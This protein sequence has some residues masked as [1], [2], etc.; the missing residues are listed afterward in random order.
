VSSFEYNTSGDITRIILPDNGIV[1]YEWYLDHS[2]KTVRYPDSGV[3]EAGY[4]LFGDVRWI[5]DAMGNRSG[6]RYDMLRQVSR[7]VKNLNGV[8]KS[9]EF[10]YNENGQVT[11]VTDARGNSTRFD[12]DKAG[13]VWKIH[14][15]P[16]PDFP[17]GTMEQYDYDPAGNL[18]THTDSKGKTTSFLYDPNG[19]VREVIR[20][21]GSSVTY[22]YD[23]NGNALKRSDHFPTGAGTGDQWNPVQPDT[24][25]DYQYDS[26]DRLRFV[27]CKDATGKI[28][29]R[30]KTEYDF[31][32]AVTD[33]SDIFGYQ[34][35]TGVKYGQGTVIGQT[36]GV[37]YDHVYTYGTDAGTPSNPHTKYGGGNIGS[38]YG[39]PGYGAAIKYGQGTKSS[40]LH[41]DNLSRITEYTD[42]FGNQ[43]HYGYDEL[44]RPAVVQYPN[45]IITQYGYDAAGRLHNITHKRETG[46]TLRSFTYQYDLNRN[47][48]KIT[49]EDGS[50]TDYVYDDWNR[51]TRET[52]KNALGMTTL[53]IAYSF[54]TAGSDQYGDTGNI[55]SKIV[56]RNGGTPE[57]TTFTYDEYNKLT[58]INHPGNVAE[59]LTYNAN[60][61]L[62]QSTKTG[63]GGGSETT[64]YYWNDQGFLTKVLLP[65][66]EPVEY[67]YDGV[68]RLV[69]RKDADGEQIFV[70][71]GWSIMTEQD[72]EGRR[73]YYTGSSSQSNNST[74]GA[75]FF[76]FNHRGDTVLIT[77]QTGEVSNELYYE[78]YG[79]VTDN[80]GTPIPANSI[81]TSTPLPPLFVG[82]Y[83]IRYD[84]K[85]ELSYMRFRWYDV[86]NMRS[87]SSDLLLDI[88]RYSYGKQNPINWFDPFGL[89]DIIFEGYYPRQEESWVF[90][91]MA[92]TMANDRI[93]AG[94]NVVVNRYDPTMVFITTETDSMAPWRDYTFTPDQAVPWANDR[95]EKDAAQFPDEELQN[96]I[97]LSH[98]SEHGIKLGINANMANLNIRDLKLPKHSS[99]LKVWV[100][101]CN[102]SRFASTFYEYFNISAMG[103]NGPTYYISPVSPMWNFQVPNKLFSEKAWPF[104]EI[105]PGK[106]EDVQ[107]IHYP[108]AMQ[109][110]RE[111]IL[112]LFWNITG[113]FRRDK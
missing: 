16:T 60:G 25:T 37:K 50:L 10:E 42:F 34:Y 58:T 109:S 90:D 99:N 102:G 91:R 100:F 105:Y 43:Y 85:T 94:I 95:F 112:S 3:V 48:T 28:L 72:T 101:S 86:N 38:Q 7:T 78:A 39:E 53:D 103:A 61:Q 92:E 54:Q 63:G 57:T 27:Q 14:Y 31:T 24:V 12:Y 84:R 79:K 21:D 46:E 68:G 15:P 74:E 35:G 96:I 89:Y 108:T 8:E 5:E 51:L 56:T 45:G 73:T 82:A 110:I 4:D 2:L 1:V 23:K 47:I 9:T 18:T 80:T 93:N 81:P 19:R 40:A 113:V 36:D 66:G 22:Q 104:K 83:G 106:S 77:D 107:F 87:I 75:N 44:T 41:Y 11:K 59:T 33:F 6:V 76:L 32:N 69:G 62:T 52:W 97:I 29:F 26:N 98:G 17:S 49:N 20:A 55:C 64:K 30:H 111:Y 65:S 70:Q 71:S 88:N 67:K 13:N